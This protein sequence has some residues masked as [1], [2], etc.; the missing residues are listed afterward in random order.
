MKYILTIQ[1]IAPFLK[2]SF[3]ILH[4]T[5]YLNCLLH[6]MPLLNLKLHPTMMLSSKT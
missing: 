5:C 1:K 6:Q 4:E 3:P 2:A